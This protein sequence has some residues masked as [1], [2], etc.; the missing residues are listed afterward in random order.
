MGPDEAMRAFRDLGAQWFVP[1][2][3]GSFRL[4]F[5]DVEEPPLWLQRIAR[6]EGMT[7]HVK[8]LEEGVPVVF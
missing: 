8:M 1:M 4:A 5:E 6:R 7:R 3:Y 2:H